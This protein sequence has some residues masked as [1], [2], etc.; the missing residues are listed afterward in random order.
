MQG[1]H[2]F[3]QPRRPLLAF[4]KDHKRSAQTGFGRT[5]I[6]RRAIAGLFSQRAPVGSDRLSQPRCSALPP[7]RVVKRIAETSLSSAPIER[8][9]IASVFLLRFAN[10]GDGIF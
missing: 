8:R 2:S 10:G 5:P 3:P 1:S 4:P 7:T 6:Q 9:A